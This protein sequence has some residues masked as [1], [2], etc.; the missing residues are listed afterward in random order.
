MATLQPTTRSTSRER[1]PSSHYS[2]LSPADSD[3]GSM[4]NGSCI[5]S[6]DENRLSPAMPKGLGGMLK[7]T[8]ETG[9]IG[10][11]SIKPSRVQ[12]PVNNPRR[13][14][15]PYN[16]D[17]MQKPRQFQPYGVPSI[18]DRR[19]LPSYARDA[20]SEVISMYE[21]A[22]QKSGG[23]VFD[24]P[25]YHS[26]SMTQTYSSYSLSN[27]RSYAS[28]RSQP[29]PGG[30]LQR[31]RSPFAY[32]TRLKRPGFR[33]SSPALTD[34]G[35]IDYS[36][37]AEIDRIP[38]VSVFKL[39]PGASAFCYVFVATAWNGR[40]KLF[41]MGSAD[42]NTQ[43][44][45]HHTSSPASLYAQKRK[46]QL[47]LRPEA[48]RSTPS[49]LSQ[50]SP[51]RRSPSPNMRQ[52]S[53]TPNNDWQRRNGPASVTT[54]PA[55]STFSLASTVNLYP[56]AHAPSTITPGKIPPPSPL[57]YDY[58][59]DFDI[60]DYNQP[61]PLEPPPQFRIDKTIPEDRPLSSEWASLNGADMR[62][63]KSSFSSALRN[64]S[65]TASALQRSLESS[66]DS[67]INT[68]ST[69]VC[70]PTQG[71]LN[72][73]ATIMTKDSSEKVTVNTGDKKVIRL[74]GLGVG[75]RELS[76]HVEEAFGLPPTRS[77]EVL[78]SNSTTDEGK[79]DD[80]N[81][82]QEDNDIEIQSIRT[83]SYSLN[84]HLGR[85][86][87]PPRHLDGQYSEMG[88]DQA[89]TLTSSTGLPLPL[90]DSLSQSISHVGNKESAVTNTGHHIAGDSM[91]SLPPRSSSVRLDRKRLSHPYS[92]DNGLAELGE[93]INAF[94]DANSM[95]NLTEKRYIQDASKVL[96][97]LPPTV[98]NGSIFGNTSPGQ[99]FNPAASSFSRLNNEN[100]LKGLPDQGLKRSYQR[101]RIRRLEAITVPT[102]SENDTPNFSHQ[103]SRKLMSSSESPMLAPKPISPARQLKLK[104]SVPQLMKALPPIPPDPSVRAVS[105]PAQL[106]FSEVELPCRFSPLMPESRATPPQEPPRSAELPKTQYIEPVASAEKVLEPV[107]L[108][109]VPAIIVAEQVKEEHKVPNPPPPPKL[110]LKMRSTSTLRPTSPP[111]S[112]P[113]N[114]EESYPW[115][116]QTFNVGLPAV[117]QED[118]AADPKPPK[119]RLKIT[120]A[121]NSTVGTVRV[122][123]ELGG[124]RTSAG[125]NLRHPKDLFTPNSGIDNIFRQVSR[126]IQS[127]KPSADSNHLSDE[128]RPISTSISD[129]IPSIRSLSSDLNNPQP[130][131]TSLNATSL[132]EV[133]SFFSDDSSHRHEGGGGL[134]KRFS[135][136]RARIAAPYGA[137]NGTQSYDNIAWGDVNGAEVP[138]P[139]AS[140]SN[141]NVHKR[142]ASTEARS[143]QRLAKRIHAQRLRAR[144]T[145]WFNGARSA[146][147]ARV[148]SR[149]AARRRDNDQV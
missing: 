139:S 33:P 94:E 77:F 11:F 27:H 126:H 7:T 136:L 76:T 81:V 4:R 113:W 24:D 72:H 100:D 111:E 54:S 127:R 46:P 125:L 122:N 128:R 26:Y 53:G 9:D 19:R 5:I 40:V 80:R 96:P 132:T 49:L 147:R 74:S 140:R 32:P 145:A 92:I 131:L 106:T 78:V 138:I 97:A 133:R 110:R 22:S 62:G 52:R 86:P 109:P 143:S 6:A 14:C 121:S 135:N 79:L 3:R 149:Q 104:N 83:S 58:T 51:Q 114:S 123:R 70:S 71:H 34:G 28:L 144:F 102:G 84:T 36:R 1:G 90:Q 43:G 117:V 107:E 18:D 44:A 129:Q 20:S 93:L 61:E 21:T 16:D 35:G 31:P 2:I 101:H 48:N 116:S 50:S 25:D 30:L 59:E 57:Y 137:A 23:R 142:R 12:L 146:I 95:K 65:S 124:S 37:R 29:D 67:S 55:R 47:S 73:E 88:T 87:P 119:F 69:S 64:S 13:I 118:K 17:G 91:S 115:S 10:L 15:G 45:N 141:P 130:S 68:Q 99:R 41:R 56:T 60:D 112:R 8:T 42:M 38:S 85:F 66:Q 82:G 103:F 148:K 108:D 120:R 89:M 98:P 105:P 63:Q 39:I 134:R 75:A